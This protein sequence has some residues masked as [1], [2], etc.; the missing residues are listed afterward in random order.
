MN[1]FIRYVCSLLAVIL[2]CPVFTIASA[3]EQHR[4]VRVGGMPFGLTMYTGGVIVVN[5]DKNN[6]SPAKEAG[7]RENDIITRAN[8]NEIK[9]NEQLQE[10]IRSSEGADIELSVLRGK[11]P[12]SLSITPEQDESGSYTAGMWIRDSTAGLGTITYFDESTHSFGALGH[13][14]CDRDTGMLLPLGTGQIVQAEITSITK[15]KKGVAGG[16]NGTMTDAAIGEMTLNNGYG[17]Y[18]KYTA[19]P[20]GEEY[21]CAFDSEIR[22]GKATICTTVDDTGIGEYE[23]EIENLNLADNSGQNMVIRVTDEELLEKTGGIVQGMSG[24]PIIQDGRLV[25]AVTHVFI[26][27]PEK[28][29][30][31]TI[32]NMLGCYEQFGGLKG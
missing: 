17:V 10:I 12:I 16:L 13:G 6:D 3:E 19:E 24:S 4:T 30:G 31:I 9:S 23:V 26:N 25:G 15:A 18:G 7:I 14:I 29:Y 22:T 8:G 2:L 5:V 11:S 27:S 21:P 32:G 20:S 28:G 1:K